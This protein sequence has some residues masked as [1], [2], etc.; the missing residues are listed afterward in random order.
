VI[1][2]I[3]IFEKPSH[4]TISIIKNERH[5]IRNKI[6]PIVLTIDHSLLN[7]RITKIRIL[8]LIFL[9]LSG[10]PGK[11]RQREKGM[12]FMNYEIRTNEC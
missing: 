10:L 6:Y 9:R 7:I 2:A 3:C 12:D 1:P 4:G 11:S 8:G 5:E